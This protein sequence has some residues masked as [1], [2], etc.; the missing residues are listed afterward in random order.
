MLATRRLLVVSTAMLLAS[1]AA[2]AE[3]SGLP[4]ALPLKTEDAFSPR[5]WR[6]PPDEDE[7]ALRREAAAKKYDPERLAANERGRK[8]WEAQQRQVRTPGRRTLNPKPYK[9]K[10]PIPGKPPKVRA[11]WQ[12]GRAA[13]DG[14]PPAPSSNS[15]D[16]AGCAAAGEPP[17]TN[18]AS[19]TVAAEPPH[20]GGGG[21]GSAFAAEK[22]MG[23]QQRKLYRDKVRAIFTQ[24][25]D[26]YMA[27]A[28]PL[29]ELKPISCSSG[30]FDPC[31]LPMLT[32]V[33]ALDT[34]AVL[35]NDT[36]FALAVETVA[37]RATAPGFF[38]LDLKVNVF[39]T[40]IRW[41]GGLLSAHCLAV[42]G[43]ET[44]RFRVPGYK[45]GLL[46]A[47]LDLGKRLLPA[48]ET[49]TGI[50]FGT[51]N[52]RYGVPKGE[53]PVAS[54]AGAGSLSIE[55]GMLSYLLCCTPSEF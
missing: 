21:A 54:V 25:F 23:Q 17:S 18:G 55:F 13:G 44:G 3:V 50:P 1:S 45:G 14:A 51:V 46:A 10:P 52:L 37:Q 36:Q 27:H 48:F 15:G 2:A 8:A 7:E 6:P 49:K 4:G 19:S 22:P 53:V 39:E 38:D 47:A 34:L 26:A 16:G 33:D 35:G 11:E 31:E 30:G 41:L 43:T 32:L 5:V 20:T 24:A 9:M 42:D 29:P 40:T 12:D 28:F